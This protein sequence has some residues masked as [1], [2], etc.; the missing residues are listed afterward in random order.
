M[1][2]EGR[3][4]S[5]TF[6]CSHAPLSDVGPRHRRPAYFLST[7]IMPKKS[8]LTPHAVN[9]TGSPLSPINLTALR[10]CRPLL[11][12]DLDFDELLRGPATFVDGGS[13]TDSGGCRW[14]GPEV[15]SALLSINDMERRN[16]ALLDAIESSTTVSYSSVDVGRLDADAI[17][18]AFVDSLR[19]GD[20]NRKLY[21]VLDETLRVLSGEQNSDEDDIDMDDCGLFADRT[22]VPGDSVRKLLRHYATR[23]LIRQHQRVGVGGVRTSTAAASGS[24]TINGSD[25]GESE[26]KWKVPDPDIT[27]EDYVECFTVATRGSRLQPEPWIKHAKAS[28]DLDSSGSGNGT[29]SF[30]GT[31]VIVKDTVFRRLDRGSLP[32]SVVVGLKVPPPS[33]GSVY[34]VDFDYKFVPSVTT[35]SATMVA[36]TTMTSQLELLPP[37]RLQPTVTPKADDSS[38]QSGTGAVVVENTRSDTFQSPVLSADDSRSLDTAAVPPLPPKPRDLALGG[39]ISQPAVRS[40][41]RLPPLPTVELLI[42]NEDTASVDEPSL[43]APPIPERKP[44]LVTTA[45]MLCDSTVDDEASV[46]SPLSEAIIP[47][48]SPL[49]PTRRGTGGSA[50]QTATPGNTSVVAATSGVVE[51]DSDPSTD[52]D[53]GSPPPPQLPPR[54]YTAVSRPPLPLPTAS[55][56]DVVE[57]GHNLPLENEKPELSSVTADPHAATASDVNDALS[58]MVADETGIVAKGIEPLSVRS[59]SV[60][61][62]TSMSGRRPLSTTS[63]TTTETASLP[64]NDEIVDDSVMNRPISQREDSGIVVSTSTCSPTTRGL[65]DSPTETTSQLDVVV[66]PQSSSTFSD[67]ERTLTYSDAVER[68]AADAAVVDA[69]VAESSWRTSD[70]VDDGLASYGSTAGGGSSGSGEVTT[71]S[72]AGLDS[73]VDSLQSLPRRAYGNS[74]SVR[75][76]RDAR[77]GND[78]EDDEDASVCDE[79]DLSEIRIPAGEDCVDDDDLDR[80]STE[81]FSHYEDIE[82]LPLE[83]IYLDPR[84]PS[85]STTS[86]LTAGRTP[87]SVKR[88]RNDP[89]TYGVGGESNIVRNGYGR[90]STSAV[91]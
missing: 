87:S 14:I 36:S 48:A 22:S 91:R 83:N 65:P 73:G 32:T 71:S 1:P 76:R 77:Q 29:T 41:P 68:Y 47:S 18:S 53:S 40:A 45:T 10:R 69:S 30:D 56:P 57:V 27:G 26:P 2:T 64:D 50:V 75:Q 31:V 12:K 49:L 55:D 46:V 59:A 88:R 61:E 38:T 60:D 6:R 19:V 23:Q 9:S 25:F 72:V 70:P 63:I 74:A 84:R 89:T 15:R 7:V 62:T 44:K 43:D 34:V 66:E 8:K 90:V 79:D 37:P 11:V 81:S 51:C 82:L 67:D 28:C 85:D 35:V 58:E 17:F 21:A 78:Y 42:N 39:V 80:F 4:D 3:D 52:S 86:S 24:Q 54:S 16:V 13:V 5:S 20:R 33:F